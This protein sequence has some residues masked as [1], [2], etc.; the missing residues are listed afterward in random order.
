MRLLATP[1]LLLLRCDANACVRVLCVVEFI[2]RKFLVCVAIIKT[3]VQHQERMFYSASE[4]DS[5]HSER[6]KTHEHAVT[7][8]NNFHS[9]YGRRNG[10]PGQLLTQVSKA[11]KRIPRH[12]DERRIHS[13]C[14]AFV[15]CLS[16]CITVIPQRQHTTHCNSDQFLVH[17][18]A[19]YGSR[20]IA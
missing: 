19:A 3:T 7:P 18:R 5:E 13:G 11:A 17:H 20:R 9:I 14:L 1:L 16:V 15:F 8:S 6:T 4:S 12:S 2:D 10:T